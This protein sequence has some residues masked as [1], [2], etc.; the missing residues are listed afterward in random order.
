MCL[1]PLRRWS[2]TIGFRLAIWY[3]AIFI[4]SSVALALLAYFFLSSSIEQRDRQVIQ[5]KLKEYQAQYEKGGIDLLRKKVLSERRSGKRN[6]FFVRMTGPTGKTFFQSIPDQWADWNVQGIG[7]KGVERKIQWSSLAAANDENVLEIAS[8][9]LRDG[10]VLQVGKSTEGRE[11]LLEHFRAVFFSVLVPMILIGFLGGHLLAVRALRPIRELVNTVRSVIQT[12]KMDLRI[13]S[14]NT[15]D[16][17]DELIVLFNKML[18]KIEDLIRGMENALDNVAHDLRTPLA[19]LRGIAEMA[20]QSDQT[21]ETCQ[22]A[23]ADCLEESE[24]VLTMMNALMDIAEAETGTL[25]LD[26]QSV[27]ISHLLENIVELYRYVAEDKNIT[28][29]TKKPQELF[30]TADPNKMRQVL[31]NLLDNAVKYTPNGGRVDVEAYLRQH[32][33]TILIRDTGMGILPE[34]IPKIW[35]RLYRGDQSRSQRGLGLG[36]SL[37]KAIVQA[38]G[39]HVEVSSQPGSGSLFVIYLPQNA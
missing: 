34:E 11:E 16:E 33:L 29:C 4:L 19:R 18:G 39:G 21:R 20:L 15:R 22:D 12:G 3:S 26:L 28:L 37:S 23:L 24:R 25:K 31:A 7:I 8:L 2:K 17:L 35:D 1:R 36:L 6:H 30:V 5:S 9:G 10:H 38:H 32:Q 13:P 27:D 14:K